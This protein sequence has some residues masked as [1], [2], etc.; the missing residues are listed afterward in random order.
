MTKANRAACLVDSGLSGLAQSSE[1]VTASRSAMMI[2]V[3]MVRN[4]GR[5]EC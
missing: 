3:V 4:D 1:Q 2:V 5:L